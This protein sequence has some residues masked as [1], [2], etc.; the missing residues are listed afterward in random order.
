MFTTRTPSE[1]LKSPTDHDEVTARIMSEDGSINDPSQMRELL[2]LRDDV[3]KTATVQFHWN[4]DKSVEMKGV[5]RDRQGEDDDNEIEPGPVEGT[6]NQC[7]VD[8][9][10]ANL[11]YE[12]GSFVA[13]RRDHD[14]DPLPFWIG[15]IVDVQNLPT[16]VAHELT[17][18][19]YKFY[20]GADFYTGT[21][22]QCYLNSQPWI[23]RISVD[24]ALVTFIDLRSGKT[25]PAIVARH[26]RER[27]T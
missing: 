12:E 7:S 10:L 18:Q 22:K 9:L 23:D 19:W 3:Y 14:N 13:V 8:Q 26:L 15:R 27:N 5:Q 25:L 16:G 11:D 4:V 21:Y 17:I 2:S 20:R 24:T 1:E 6:G